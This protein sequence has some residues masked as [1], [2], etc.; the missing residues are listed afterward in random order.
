MYRFRFRFI[1][2]ERDSAPVRLAVVGGV[3]QPPPVARDGEANREV[4][5]ERHGK[6]GHNGEL[7]C[8]RARRR[9]RLLR[10][11]PGE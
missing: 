11:K 4:N 9:C 8:E 10:T 3:W 2:R 6:D 5:N 1:Y 7:G